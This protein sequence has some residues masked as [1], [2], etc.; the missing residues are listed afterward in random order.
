M[1]GCTPVRIGLASFGRKSFSLATIVFASGSKFA[2]QAL[3]SGSSHVASSVA[4]RS[5]H[6]HPYVRSKDLL[7]LISRYRASVAI[8]SPVKCAASRE[9]ISLARG[10]VRERL[11]QSHEHPVP[12]HRGVPV[13]AAEKRR[14]EIARHLRVRRR[15]EDMLR[16][17]REL[18]VNARERELRKRFP[19]SR[20]ERNGVRASARHHSCNKQQH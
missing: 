4:R 11:E 6:A 5:V 8:A 19:L 20:R 9:R 18:A 13:V 12:V 3:A 1:L 17:V 2:R 14:M 7:L 16:L 15:I 10:E